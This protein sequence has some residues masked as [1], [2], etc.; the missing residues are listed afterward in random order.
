VDAGAPFKEEVEQTE[1]YAD[2]FKCHNCMI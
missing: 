1:P 2:V